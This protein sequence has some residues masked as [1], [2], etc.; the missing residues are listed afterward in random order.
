MVDGDCLNPKHTLDIV[1][2]QD[3]E[4]YIA[5]PR[6]PMRFVS[7][8]G[9]T[10]SSFSDSLTV[11]VQGWGNDVMFPTRKLFQFTAASL[12][13]LK[14]QKLLNTNML[15]MPSMAQKSCKLAETLKQKNIKQ[16]F[17]ETSSWHTWHGK[18]VEFKSRGWLVV[19]TVLLFNLRKTKSE[20]STQKHRQN[21]AEPQATKQKEKR[22]FFNSGHASSNA[23]RM[24]SISLALVEIIKFY[25]KG[26]LQMNTSQMLGFML[27]FHCYR[28]N[29]FV[30]W[31]RFKS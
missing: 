21:L 8:I 23:E 31:K 30:K 9:S 3:W 5:E 22:A 7:V 12:G 10:P 28:A 1:K 4:W 19:P 27:V 16:R 13:P 14:S 6:W 26:T 24:R 17:H 11:D 15:G 29:R 25:Q 2:H 18:R 20:S